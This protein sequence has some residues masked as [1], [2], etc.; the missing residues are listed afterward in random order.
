VGTDKFKRLSVGKLIKKKDYILY[1]TPEGF[2][3]YNRIKNFL[4]EQTQTF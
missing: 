2:D 1:F 3:D 4:D